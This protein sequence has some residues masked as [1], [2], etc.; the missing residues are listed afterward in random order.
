[1]MRTPRLTPAAV[2]HLAGRPLLLRVSPRHG[3]CGG[4]ALLPVAE[5]GSP[6]DPDA[7]RTE[8]IDGVTYFVDPRLGEDLGN[9]T[10]D[11][12]GIERWKRLHIDGAEGVNPSP[13]AGPH[14]D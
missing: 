10:I 11:A 2:A 8:T 12:S 7:Y 5:V 1:M 13:A 14:H 4:H 9:W 6:D 3:C